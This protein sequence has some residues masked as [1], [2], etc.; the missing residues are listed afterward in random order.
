MRREGCRYVAFVVFFCLC[1][2]LLF[3]GN[4]GFFFS[5]FIVVMVFGIDLMKILRCVVL[6]MEGVRVWQYILGFRLMKN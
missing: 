3:A 6:V 5:F 4:G 2:D 1:C